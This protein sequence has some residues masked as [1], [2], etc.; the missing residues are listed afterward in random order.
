MDRKESILAVAK[1]IVPMLDGNL[2]AIK[3][4]NQL[5]FEIAKNL[6]TEEAESIVDDAHQLVATAETLLKK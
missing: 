4:Y 6:G 2:G 3:A 1:L 5:E